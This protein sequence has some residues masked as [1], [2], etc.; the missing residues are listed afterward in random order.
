M[1]FM[2][3]ALEQLPEKRLQKVGKLGGARQPERTG[4][5]CGSNDSGRGAKE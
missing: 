1:L 2:E 5:T 3:L 4:A